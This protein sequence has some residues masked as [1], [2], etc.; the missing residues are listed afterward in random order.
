MGLSNRGLHTFCAAAE[1]LS[2]KKTA[3]ELCLTPSAVSHQI[4]ELEDYLGTQLFK[5]KTR[6]IALTNDGSLLYEEVS[7]YLKAIDLATEKIRQSRKRYALQVQMP[8]FFAS[9]LL[10]P[11]ISEF[12]SLHTDI[13]LH[14]RRYRHC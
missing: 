9:E 1:N 7:P 8:E 12:T 4:S 2:F 3:N 14:Y 5:R 11:H 6:S 13:D 10:M